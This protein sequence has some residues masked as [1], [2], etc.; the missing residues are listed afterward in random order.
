M[1]RETK[2]FWSPCQWRKM[3]WQNLS[4]RALLILTL[5]TPA[6]L[7]ISCLNTST[8]KTEIM[9]ST[10][11]LESEQL[12]TTRRRIAN[13][14]RE[15]DNTILK[16]LREKLNLGQLRTNDV[17]TMKGATSWLTLPLKSE[18][19]D[20]NKRKFYVVLSLRYPW[21]LKCLSST[22]PCGKRFD[23]DHAVRCMKGGFVHRRHD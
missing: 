2:D 19:I 12:M 5:S 4:S 1:P 23:V 21:K 18:N 11:S 10:A 3:N 9:I 15:L 16:Q 17:I 8:I 7:L 14:R 20:L 6:H 13:T 22:C